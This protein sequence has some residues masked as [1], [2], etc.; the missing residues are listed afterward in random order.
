MVTVGDETVGEVFDE[1]VFPALFAATVAV[2]AVA[3]AVIGRLVGGGG[4]EL[5]Q[6]PT[7]WQLGLFP[8]LP[9]LLAAVWFSLA[10]GRGVTRS[11]LF[12]PAVAVAQTCLAV[13]WFAGY[14][15]LALPAV[16]VWWLLYEQA[17]W[18]NGA[19]GVVALAALAGS[20]VL[21]HNLRFAEPVVDLI[22]DFYDS[23]AKALVLWGGALFAVA[24]ALLVGG[25]LGYYLGYLDDMAWEGGSRQGLWGAILG[26]IYGLSVGFCVPF[27]TA[28]ALM[29]GEAD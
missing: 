9:L 29:L 25:L 14:F 19:A 28:G 10:R 3:G 4:G 5:T 17:G 8:L 1:D 18:S 26:G 7:G 23:N 13:A 24:P 20:V 15:L 21:L 12:A 6:Y 16:G 11:V 27:T 2:A 22:H